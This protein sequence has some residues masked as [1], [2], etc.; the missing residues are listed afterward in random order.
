M[1]YDEPIEI[2]PIGDQ[3]WRVQT[4]LGKPLGYISWHR[5]RQKHILVQSGACNSAW[6]SEE[7]DLVSAFLKEQTKQKE[8]R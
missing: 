5:A 6:T 2:V 8:T 3:H 4:L 1:I 7:L